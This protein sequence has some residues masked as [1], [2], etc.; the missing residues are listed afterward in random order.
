VVW[1]KA[2]FSDRAAPNTRTLRRIPDPRATQFWD[3]DRLLSHEMG[4]SKTGKMIWDYAAIY[5]HDAV[6]NGTFP[7]PS[8]SGGPV[9][10]HTAEL[11]QVLGRAK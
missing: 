8:Y 2:L 7:Q 1:E 11:D 9:V 4:E 10:E 6:W 3:S 5:P